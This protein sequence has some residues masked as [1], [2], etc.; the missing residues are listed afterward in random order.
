[1]LIN[2]S[3]IISPGVRAHADELPR[4]SASH[5]E[6]EED[7]EDEDD[8]V[9]MVNIGEDLLDSIDSGNGVSSEE[10]VEKERIENYICSSRCSLYNG[11]H[12]YQSLDKMQVRDMRLNMQALTDYDKDLILIGKVST[13]MNQSEMTASTK[14]KGQKVREHQRTTYHVEGQ[15]VCRETFKFVHG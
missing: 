6:A 15:R 1:M 10:T 4:S 14:R 3:S 12:C 7:D 13:C 5:T 9:V 8:P 11:Q 2:F